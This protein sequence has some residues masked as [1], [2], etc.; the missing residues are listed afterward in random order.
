MK[1]V[2]KFQIT[3]IYEEEIEITEK[4]FEEAI[5]KYID[6]TIYTYEEVLD[7]EIMISEALE[8]ANLLTFQEKNAKIVGGDFDYLDVITKNEDED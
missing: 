2:G 8:M 7:D 3:R 1:V 5:F 4:E 6:D